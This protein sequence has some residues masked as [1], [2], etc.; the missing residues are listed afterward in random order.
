METFIINNARV[1]LSSQLERLRVLCSSHHKGNFLIMWY[2][3]TLLSMVNSMP[4]LFKWICQKLI[5]ESNRV[6]RRVATVFIKTMYPRLTLCR[7]FNKSD[8]WNIVAPPYSPRANFALIYAGYSSSPA[9]KI[10]WAR[11]EYSNLLGVKP[12]VKNSQAVGTNIIF[13]QIY[14]NILARS[15]LLYCYTEDF[16]RLSLFLF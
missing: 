8:N 5:V 16:V 4:K 1:S 9:C 11:N 12:Y 15:W 3:W 7:H 10:S 14:W 6:W 13:H 2:P